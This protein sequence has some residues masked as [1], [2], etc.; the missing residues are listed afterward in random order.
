MTPSRS[1]R[2]RVAIA[3]LAVA[4]AGLA[5]SEDDPEPRS[6]PDPPVTLPPLTTS[7]PP[8]LP[9]VPPAGDCPNQ[10]EVATNPLNRVAGPLIGDVTG[11]ATPDR[12]Y[13]SLDEAA[14]EGCQ[15]FVVVSE[16]TSLAAPVEGWDP[17]A[18][19][20]SP[21]FN[22]LYQIDGR[23]GSEVVVLLATG[24]STQFVG[25]FSAAGGVIERITTSTTGEASP[26][27]NDLF[28]FGGS[29]GHLEAVD[30]VEGRVIVSSAIPKGQRYQVTRNFYE[31][32]GATLELQ[33]SD[34]RRAVVS[35]QELEDFPEFASSPFG[36]CP[37]V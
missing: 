16:T 18:G 4:L 6:A 1:P 29:V 10:A 19:V 22:G 3:L 35:L 34:S 15:A 23:P 17:S 8:E 36:S 24:A 21:S 12:V 37:R 20:S 28:A 30:C 31:P 27:S 25:A 7:P 5:C 11:D 14:P 2:R 13:L 9:S 26:G 32:S 33:T